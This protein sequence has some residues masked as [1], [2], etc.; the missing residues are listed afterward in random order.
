MSQLNFV[1]YITNRG[2]QEIAE[3]YSLIV[4]R[5]ED[6]RKNTLYFKMDSEY[7]MCSEDGY[8]IIWDRK[9]TDAL[10][11]NER[12]LYKIIDNR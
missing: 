8:F 2:F 10:L 4:F 12:I 3:Q 11:K 5:D 9:E 1:T 7:A 6:I